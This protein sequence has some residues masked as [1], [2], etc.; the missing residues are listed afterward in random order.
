MGAKVSAAGD[1]VL[2][3]CDNPLFLHQVY[4]NYYGE[5]GVSGVLP[6][7]ITVC[8]EA[9]SMILSRFVSVVCV[10]A[11]VA[12]VGCSG[13]NSFKDGDLLQVQSEVKTTGE[14]IWEDGTSE[15][16]DCF[17]P[18]GTKLK[19]SISQVTGVSFVECTIEGIGTQTNETA[20]IH[21]IL[22]PQI[23]NRY[24]LQSFSV[25]ISTDLIGTKISRTK[26]AS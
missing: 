19:V 4:I 24:G 6:A 22:P 20:I 9:C 17:L 25:S 12:Y 3:I 23:A 14:C 21:R 7:N 10:V 1:R 2:W 15:G 18:A 26:S 5:S 16:F 13:G 11:A 8:K